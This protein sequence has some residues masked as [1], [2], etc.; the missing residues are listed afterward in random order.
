MTGDSDSTT[1]QAI[2]PQSLSDMRDD[3]GRAAH[4]VMADRRWSRW[5]PWLDVPAVLLFVVVMALLLAPP[6]AGKLPEL[7]VDSV[8]T[9]TIRAEHDLLV[10][11]KNATEMRRK[12]ALDSVPTVFDYDSELY[13]S[14]GDKVKR[15]L[16]A[17]QQRATQA[18]LSAGERRAAFEKDLGVSVKPGVFGL[19]EGLSDPGD[20]ALAIN[21]FLNMGLD[22]QVV[23][24]RTDL[25]SAG[26]I[27]I[28]D[29]A[30]GT[31]ARRDHAGGIMDLRQLRRLMAARAGDAPYG[32]ARIVRTWILETAQDLAHANLKRDDIATA[33]LRENAMKSVQP[34][35]LR[36]EAGEVLV[37]KGDR[38]SG[39]VEEKLRLLNAHS[40]NRTAWGE[41]AA[42]GGLLAA[43]MALGGI[44]F[45][46]GRVP[47]SFGRKAAY[48]A[49]AVSGVTTAIAVAMFFAGLGLAE[50]IGFDAAAAPYFVPLAL[51]TVLVS[52]LVDARTSLLV[53]IAMTLLLAYRMNGD[54]ALV[55]YYVLGVLV[56]GIAARHS[57]RRTDLLRI[58]VAVA[59][60][61][62]CAIPVT[63]ILSGQSI[64]M[65][66]LPYVVA[67]LVSGGLVG[68]L[69]LGLLPVAELAFDETTD[70]RLLELAS[71]DS[72]LLKELAIKA[73]GTYYHATMVA[74][75]SEAG[76][77]AI[78]ANGLMCRVM[79][80][81]HDIGKIRRPSYF[82]ENQRGGENMHDRLPPDVSARVV[83]AHIRDGIEIA[84]RHRLGRAILD[85][86]TQH[87][88]TCLLHS[89][90][91][92]A[93]A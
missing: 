68:V 58:G 16:D 51:G 88:G 9:G 45:S 17:L 86:I 63:I 11:D 46:R 3:L 43:I 20:V 44:F 78:G 71:A 57:R 14:L 21:F 77:D 91:D 49:L 5:R 27:Q 65:E 53:G 89:F 83:F 13:F 48:I 81:Y 87:Q 54:L 6:G 61:Q 50:G 67:A 33:E 23:A 10:Q 52:L 19:I 82:M 74:N 28:R 31:V 1:D 76:A 36:I 32:S 12:A 59:V 85:G 70:P 41:T 47:H 40:Q 42:V 38:V 8:A 2:E 35:F 7:P 25:P 92:K 15:A 37:R 64:G 72:P 66:H 30:L 60:A 55:T 79:A 80:L 69:T 90:Y 4:A 84:R 93:R 56:A 26:V 22:R 73:P 62:A 29:T 39:P 18:T 24:D 34:V 75:L